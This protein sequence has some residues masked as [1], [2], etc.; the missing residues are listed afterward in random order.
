[1]IAS[2]SRSEPTAGVDTAVDKLVEELTNKLHAGSSVNIEDYVQQYPEHASLIRQVF[3]A[4]EVMAELGRSSLVGKA[5]SGATVLEPGAS[6]LL[7]TLGDYRIIREVGRG[8]MGV[9]YEATQLSLG[10][11]VALKVLPL[12]AAL[13]PRQRQRFQV[14]AQAAAQLHHT[15]I[16]PVFAVGCERGVHYYAMQLIE[17]QS[18]A[19]LISEMQWFAQRAEPGAAQIQGPRSHV[20]DLSPPDKSEPGASGPP[21][22]GPAIANRPEGT[23]LGDLSAEPASGLRTA[24]KPP[25]TGLSNRNREF[26]RTV[27]RL[28]V[29]AAEALEHAHSLG[30]LHRDIKPANLI[31]DSRGDVWITDFGLA[32]LQ[33]EA[34]L[35]LTGDLL[36]TL[37]YM[38]PEQALGKRV[39]IDHRT[40]IYSLGVTVYELIALRTALQGRNHQELLHQ[41]ASEEPVPLRRINPA[42]PRD[43][44]TIVLKAMAKEPDARYASAQDLADDLQRFLDDKPIRARRPSP[45]EH[46]AKWTRRHRP[47]VMTA[48][49]VLLLAL[50]VGISLLWW[51]QKKTAAALQASERSLNDWRQ[52]MQLLLP[53]SSALTLKAMAIATTYEAPPNEQEKEKFLKDAL[54]FYEGWARITHGKP[55][56]LGMEAEATTRVGLTRMIMRLPTA[57]EAYLRAIALYEQLIAE[58]PRERGPREKIVGVLQYRALMMTLTSGFPKAER[59]YCRSLDISRGL[60][61]DFP[62]KVELYTTLIQQTLTLAENYEQFMQDPRKAEQARRGLVVF[63]DSLA[64]EV[65]SVPQLRLPLAQ[66][67]REL[68]SQLAAKGLHREAVPLFRK[69]LELQPINPPLLNNLAWFYVNDPAQPAYDPDEGI[70]LAKRAVSAD[71]S[72]AAAWNTLSVAF[73]RNR[74][75]DAAIEALEKSMQLSSGGLPRDYLFMAMALWQ[76]GEREDADNWYMKATT[77][78]GKDASLDR[79]PELKRFQAEAATLLGKDAPSQPKQSESKID[80]SS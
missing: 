41:I 69:S 78:I 55:E 58:S 20:V 57:D 56:L 54:K 6:G 8:G 11:R 32:R 72:S 35:T 46:M 76:K 30:V 17:G 22:T 1:M 66:A 16:V 27:A 49:S 7:D 9:V 28:G 19:A 39:V 3:S 77:T 33:N 12:A 45:L 37:R 36:G 68:G 29:Q 43:L 50:I 5:Q 2:R 65:P 34:G 14:E 62:E 38:S 75:W 44:E 15:H 47:V 31:V 4:L 80:K 25:S 71:A 70:V 42:I 79:D 59:D 67:Y 53:A 51:Q 24:E 63:F 18:L 21:T 60:V 40:D 23:A 64:D 73:Y 74:D 61:T 48:V 10:R 52:A 13:D 26:F